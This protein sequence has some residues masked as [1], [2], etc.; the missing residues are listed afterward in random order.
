MLLARSR[1]SAPQACGPHPCIQSGAMREAAEVGVGAGA[2]LKEAPTLP[3]ELP[4]QGGATRGALAWRLLQM[5]G[6]RLVRGLFAAAR[7]SSPGIG[8]RVPVTGMRG[9]SECMYA[10]HTEACGE[11]ALCA[12]RYLLLVFDHPC[13]PPFQALH[14][15]VSASNRWL[16]LRTVVANLRVAAHLSFSD[17]LGVSFTALIAHTLAGSSMASRSALD[18]V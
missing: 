7:C 11:R 4:Q 12:W 5:G 10:V 2:A 14:K 13:T 17:A 15:G 8:T 3:S 18:I 1:D 9:S 16:H 6:V